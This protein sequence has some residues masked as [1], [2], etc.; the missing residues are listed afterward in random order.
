ML[1]PAISRS[2]ATQKIGVSHRLHPFPD[3]PLQGVIWRF[4]SQKQLLHTLSLPLIPTSRLLRQNST[5]SRYP[6]P[7]LSLS[8]I[9]SFWAAKR[10]KKLPV[11]HRLHLFFIAEI[12]TVSPRQILNNY[13]YFI[14]SQFLINSLQKL[15]TIP[16]KNTKKLPWILQNRFPQ[17]LILQKYIII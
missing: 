2:S 12:K 4:N 10:T 3:I 16:S 15:Y 9:L 13:S 11:V 7:V 5:L 14:F 8:M 6:S 17:Q 1:L